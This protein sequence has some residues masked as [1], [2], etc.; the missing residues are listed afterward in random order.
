MTR[1]L[2]RFV[3]MLFV[4][5]STGKEIT[6]GKWVFSDKGR[7][8]SS[9]CDA[10]PGVVCVPE[11]LIQ[12]NAE[13]NSS[14]KAL[15]VFAQAGINCS[16]VDLDK[17]FDPSSAPYYIWMGFLGNQCSY[18]AS[19]GGDCTATGRRSDEVRLCWCEPGAGPSP[20]PKPVEECT[21]NV[22]CPA[23]DCHGAHDMCL[24]VQGGDS[25]NTGC[26]LNHAILRGTC[27]WGGVEK[28][29]CCYYG[30]TTAN[31]TNPKP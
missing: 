7:S 9:A 10:T 24:R 31:T 29:A 23:V 12:H 19:V 11:K 4:A 6:T 26:R 20:K 18:T 22:D 8:C 25:G 16:S 27:E 1:M 30:G 21:W 14:A 2:G 3:T 13:V 15:H 5:T 17:D 28:G